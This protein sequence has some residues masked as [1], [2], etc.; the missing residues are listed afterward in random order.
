MQSSRA[1]VVVATLAALG[2]PGCKRPAPAPSRIRVAAAS[3]LGEAFP[4]VAAAFTRESHVEIDFTFG[5]SGVLA[6]QVAEGAPFDLFASANATFA[7]AAVASGACDAAT[8]AAY[9]RGKL[10]L[11]CPGGAPRDLTALADPK[12]RTVALASPDHAPYGR[13]AV[14]AL[15]RAGLL[16]ALRPKLVFAGNVG[17]SL[18]FARSGNADCAFVSKALVRALPPSQVLELAQATYAPIVQQLVVCGSSP[19]GREAARAFGDFVRG[20][21]GQRILATYGFGAPEESP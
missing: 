4:E 17:E 6:K 15:E 7:D 16:A 11:V 12:V 8:K 2:A 21:S 14:D 3:D 10:V 1:A 9:A 13:A 18:Q 19:R 20:P 5:S